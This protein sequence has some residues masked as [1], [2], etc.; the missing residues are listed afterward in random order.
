MISLCLAL[1]GR[2]W[3]YVVPLR[4]V[5]AREVFGDEDVS[6]WGHPHR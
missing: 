5:P 4:T 1:I 6:G 3:A 2:L